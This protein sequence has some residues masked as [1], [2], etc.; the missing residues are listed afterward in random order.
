MSAFGTKR[1]WPGLLANCPTEMESAMADCIVVPKARHFRACLA[2][3][4]ALPCLVPHS[5]GR[6][7][8]GG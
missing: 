6:S 7:P 1:T 2:M 5:L 4:C 3:R 8:E